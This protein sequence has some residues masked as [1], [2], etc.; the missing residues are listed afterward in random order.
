[1]I[2]AA[3]GEVNMVTVYDPSTPLLALYLEDSK[4][5]YHRDPCTK[6]LITPLITIAKLQSPAQYPSREKQIKKI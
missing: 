1:M 5:A 3:P 6:M 2:S 4:T